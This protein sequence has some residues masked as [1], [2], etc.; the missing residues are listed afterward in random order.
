MPDI[1]DYLAHSAVLVV[2]LRIGGGMRLKLLEFFSSAKAVVSTSIGAEGS[3]ARDGIE[4]LLRDDDDS[5]ADAVIALLA[6]RS[7]CACL[8]N[9]GRE[10]VVREYSWQKIGEAFIAFYKETLDYKKVS[11]E[12]SAPH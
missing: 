9:A 1:R 3:Q 2:P 12:A 4:L 6:D 10:L 11:T 8:G 5:F 7:L